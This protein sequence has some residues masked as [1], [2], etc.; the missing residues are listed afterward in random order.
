MQNKSI[1]RIVVGTA[2]ILLVPLVAMQFTDEVVWTPADFV[3]AGILLA[4]SGFAFALAAKN[5]NRLA[6]KAAVGLA[7]AGALLLVWVNLAVGVIGTEHNPANMIYVGVLAVGL[8]GALIARFQ[9]P[10]MA[11][12]L[13]A[14]ALAQ[15]L[16][17][18]IALFYWPREVTW[19]VGGANVFFIVLF[20]SSGLLFRRAGQTTRGANQ[21]L[22]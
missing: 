18:A 3:T 5:A 16:V 7:V 22:G 6:H 21:K 20:V 15:A 19:T 14:T 17:L 1:I 12:T 10:G 4:G 8:T 9:P 2:L 13:Y 11:R